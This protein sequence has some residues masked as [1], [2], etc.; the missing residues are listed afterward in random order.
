[1]VQSKPACRHGH[2]IVT[3]SLWSYQKPIH[4]LYTLPGH[5]L[6]QT[7]DRFSRQILNQSDSHTKLSSL[8]RTMWLN[9]S[10]KIFSNAQHQSRVPAGY[11]VDRDSFRDPFNV[12]INGV[13]MNTNMEHVYLLFV[14]IPRK[15]FRLGS[16]NME[17]FNFCKFSKNKALAIYFGSLLISNP[18]SLL[19]GFI[20]NHQMLFFSDL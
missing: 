17:W 1:M 13:W 16:H 9:L 5:L 2:H 14:K 4:F 3:E 6:I 20:N 8:I 7:T 10:V 19:S 12:H 15:Q 18:G 11:L